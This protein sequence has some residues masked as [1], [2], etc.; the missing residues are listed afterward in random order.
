M[1]R[2]H[3]TL[4]AFVL[5]AVATA[6]LFAMSRT[7]RLGQG[8]AGGTAGSIATSARLEAGEARPLEPQPAQGEGEAPACAPKLPKFAPVQ[9]AGRGGSGGSAAPADRK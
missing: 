4:L 3:S 2:L 7:V 8:V 5:G 9:L 1:T 6:G